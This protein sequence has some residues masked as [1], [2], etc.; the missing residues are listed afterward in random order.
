MPNTN[1][2]LET[3]LTEHK[4]ALG[5]FQKLCTLIFLFIGIIVF[6]R[7]Y[8]SYQ[9]TMTHMREHSEEHL[10]MLQKTFYALTE[11]SSQE[12]FVVVK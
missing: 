11:R 6:A 2:Q 1:P 4:R 9:Q 5:L 12:L 3:A 7:S 8:V 10:A